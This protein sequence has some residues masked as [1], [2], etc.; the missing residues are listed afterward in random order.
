MA[1][2]K[3]LDSEKLEED[4][5]ENVAGGAAWE[6]DDDLH[7]FQKLGII[8]K[9]TDTPAKDL[10]DAFKRLGMGVNKNDIRGNEYFNLNIDRKF[11]T[12]ADAWDYIC[13]RLNKPYFD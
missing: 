11:K 2:E 8:S 9:N 13:E 1:E 3:I 6:T 12:R 10:Y 7:R 5:L 4:Q